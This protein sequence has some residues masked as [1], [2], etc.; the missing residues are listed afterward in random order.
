MYL[1]RG[2]QLDHKRSSSPSTTS[3]TAATTTIAHLTADSSTETPKFSSKMAVKE[4]AAGPLRGAQQAYVEQ[5]V[6]CV[7]HRS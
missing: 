1:G 6:R 7:T 5:K 3:T 4:E 2:T